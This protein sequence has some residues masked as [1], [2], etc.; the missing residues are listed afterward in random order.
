MVA[1]AQQVRALDCG[2]SGWGFESPQPPPFSIHP[3]F[4][5]KVTLC[6][7]QMLVGPMRFL[8]LTHLYRHCLIYVPGWN[9]ILAK[10]ST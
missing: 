10:K 5:P 4:M 3:T 7:Q 9:L 6:G 8:S 1:V 2:S